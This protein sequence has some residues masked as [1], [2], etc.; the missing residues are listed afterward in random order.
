MRG[1]SVASTMEPSELNPG[2]DLAKALRQG[3]EHMIGQ[4]ATVLD[5]VHHLTGEVAFGEKPWSLGARGVQVLCPLTVRWEFD[6]KHG[7]RLWRG[8]G[9]T[10]WAAYK[11]AEMRLMTVLQAQ[12]KVAAAQLRAAPTETKLP[13]FPR[14][15]L[16]LQYWARDRINE[17]WRSFDRD[18]GTN[19][20][21][22]RRFMHEGREWTFWV[23]DTAT[24][25]GVE[26]RLSDDAS[27]GSKQASRIQATTAALNAFQKACDAYHAKETIQTTAGPHYMRNLNPDR[28]MEAFLGPLDK[29]AAKSKPKLPPYTGALGAFLRAQFKGLCEFGSC[30]GGSGYHSERWPCSFGGRTWTLEMSRLMGGWL[31]AEISTSGYAEAMSS[32]AATASGAIEHVISALYDACAKENPPMPNIIKRQNPH[33]GTGAEQRAAKEARSRPM[34]RDEDFVRQMNGL[35]GGLYVQ[36]VNEGENDIWYPHS[37][38]CPSSPWGVSVFRADLGWTVQLTHRRTREYVQAVHLEF[39]TATRDALVLLSEAYP[40]H[41]RPEVLA[42]AEPA[43]GQAK[44]TPKNDRRMSMAEFEQFKQDKYGAREPLAQVE[45]VPIVQISPSAVQALGRDLAAAF[46]E[47]AP[48]PAGQLTTQRR[49]VPGTLYAVQLKVAPAGTVSAQVSIGDVV[50]MGL[51]SS[52]RRPDLEERIATAVGLAIEKFMLAASKGYEPPETSGEKPDLW[53]QVPKPHEPPKEE[54][55]PGSQHGGMKYL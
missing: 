32:Q 12:A 26:I 38:T 46:G 16:E 28:F 54:D 41:L 31:K 39:S 5:D 37:K 2:R 22:L 14:C 34:C 52:Y 6:I 33:M 50:Y 21:W 48:S 7:G 45:P 47:F 15:T 29:L 20:H 1:G 27:V 42:Q 40:E 35:A 36:W 19:D 51:V 43:A 4:V 30:A 53:R 23:S 24:G 9:R 3:A 11:E 10:M 17:T 13:L 18:A 44:P 55:W 25:F 8:T 49:L